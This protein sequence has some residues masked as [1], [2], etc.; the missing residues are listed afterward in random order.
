MTSLRQLEDFKGSQDPPD[1]DDQ[2]E[3]DGQ[4]AQQLDQST[5]RP[6]SLT[7]KCLLNN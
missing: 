5:L 6:I 4:A 7:S 1:L 2:W 3:G